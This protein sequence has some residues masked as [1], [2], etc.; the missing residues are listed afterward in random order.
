MRFGWVGTFDCDLTDEQKQLCEWVAERARAGVQRIYYKEAQA[1]LD[2]E[3]EKDLT[4]M[5]R[6]LRERLDQVHEMIQ[7]P[8]VHTNK[9]HF[10]IHPD[11]NHIW[12]RYLHAEEQVPYSEP[13]AFSRQAAPVSC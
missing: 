13:D 3:H 4:C 9:P 7:S 12:G 2:I 10:D 5:L 1:S 8:I 6:N 11:A